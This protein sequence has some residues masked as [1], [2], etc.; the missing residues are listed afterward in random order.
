M[1]WMWKVRRE[2]EDTKGFRSDNGKK[3]SSAAMQKTKGRLLVPNYFRAWVSLWCFMAKL[4]EQILALTR[5]NP[6]LPLASTFV[7]CFFFRG[8]LSQ[9]VLPHPGSLFFGRGSYSQINGTEY[10]N[11]S[12]GI[13]A[14]SL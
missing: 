2:K 1:D 8:L 11:F 7:I 10:L 14:S 4:L 9:S 6:W 5:G 13:A 3:Q 12:H